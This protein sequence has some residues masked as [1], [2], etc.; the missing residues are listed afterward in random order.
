MRVCTAETYAVRV[1][2]LLRQMG[3][4]EAYRRAWRNKL[5]VCRIPGATKLNNHIYGGLK[6]PRTKR[7]VGPHSRE[8]IIMSR[9]LVAR[10]E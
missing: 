10:Y 4:Y 9:A 2:G 1:T 8:Q 3:A 7:I 5:V 6:L